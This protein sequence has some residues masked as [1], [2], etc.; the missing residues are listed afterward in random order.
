MSTLYDTDFAEWAFYNADLLRTGRLSEADLENIAEE[1]ESLARSQSHELKSRLIQIIEHLLK[2]SLTPDDLRKRNE[3]GWRGSI[4]RQLG[5]IQILLKDSPSLKRHLSK[6]ILD[7]CY[8]VA[9][10]TFAASFEI[11]PP[12]ECPFTLEE[13]VGE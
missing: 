3:R 2:L 1:I 5:E 9:A 8:S 7:E 13:V 6:A 4:Q 12:A 11:Q 10:R